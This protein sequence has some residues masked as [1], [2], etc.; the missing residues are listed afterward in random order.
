MPVVFIFYD[1]SLAV[2]V[3]LKYLCD[4]HFAD[5]DS[6]LLNNLQISYTLPTIDELS[7]V[8]S[9]NVIDMNTNGSSYAN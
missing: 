5:M 3:I 4:A 9:I 7:S 6:K 2:S 1:R 8:V